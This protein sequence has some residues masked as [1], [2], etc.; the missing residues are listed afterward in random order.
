MLHAANSIV[1]SSSGAKNI[2]LPFLFGISNQLLVRQ[3][4]VVVV[5][6]FSDHLVNAW[7]G[8]LIECNNM[9]GHLFE[10]LCKAVVHMADDAR[11]SRIAIDSHSARS[12]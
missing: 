6:F 9:N 10:V 3:V 2:R 11:W 7:I 4:D 8:K 5:G 1:E 12:K